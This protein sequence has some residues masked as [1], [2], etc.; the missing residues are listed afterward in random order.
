MERDSSQDVLVSPTK[1]Q[2]YQRYKLP[3]APRT[4]ETGRRDEPTVTPQ[5]RPKP[6]IRYTLQT[7]KIMPFTS[8]AASVTHLRTSGA[9]GATTVALGAKPG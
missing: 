3:Y 7:C 8:H 2:R 1:E 6:R 9:I 4:Q 5:S